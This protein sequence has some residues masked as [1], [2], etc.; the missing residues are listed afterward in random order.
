MKRRRLFNQKLYT[1]LRQIESEYHDLICMEDGETIHDLRVAIRRATPLLDM[2]AQGI[3]SKKRRRKVEKA[4]QVLKGYF[5]ALSDIRDM[6]VMI[7]RIVELHPS[8]LTVLNRMS[9]EL[10]AM[11]RNALI[12]ASEWNIP[13]LIDD[14]VFIVLDKP[15]EPLKL[16]KNTIELVKIRKRDAIKKLK[17]PANSAGELHKTRIALKKL[18]YA[19]EVAESLGVKCMPMA[20]DIK[21]YQDRLGYFQDLTILM[22]YLEKTTP[23]LPLMD[24]IKALHRE[25]CTALLDES[26]DWIHTI[27]K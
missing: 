22:E 8:S 24:E 19:L 7:D 6:Q 5:D 16:R 3:S 10:K 2:Y 12:N 9:N 20:K 13:E 14:I 25:N 11:H 21:V 15:F 18:R 1:A 23:T 27:K 17:H 26:K 4:N